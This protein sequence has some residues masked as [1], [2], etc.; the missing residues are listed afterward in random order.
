MLKEKEIRD[1]IKNKIYFAEIYLKENP[2]C[3][4]TNKEYIAKEIFPYVCEE[5]N[6]IVAS[7]LFPIIEFMLTSEPYL[8]VS[9][10][11]KEKLPRNSVQLIL[12]SIK[13]FSE[14]EYYNSLISIPVIDAIINNVA[15]DYL[16]PN[17]HF[18]KCNINIANEDNKELSSVIKI[19][20]DTGIIKI[21]PLFLLIFSENGF[22]LRLRYAHHYF[23]DLKEIQLFANLY[24]I[25]LLN[26]I[27]NYKE[28]LYDIEYN[29]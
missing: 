3:L 4:L 6:N 26:I 8:R 15:N 5:N 14:G 16:L 9:T 24:I 7:L 23:K 11:Y 25:L 17:S 27:I 1:Y 12:H 2:Y 19:I 22:N 13:A 21:D 18:K 29:I 28:V 20:K 10:R